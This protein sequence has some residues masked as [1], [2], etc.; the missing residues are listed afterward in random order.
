MQVESAGGEGMLS[1][2]KSVYLPKVFAFRGVDV[3][4]VVVVADVMDYT[5][6]AVLNT[7]YVRTIQRG[8]RARGK[9]LVLIPIGNAIAFD[10]DSQV[11]A[12]VVLPKFSSVRFFSPF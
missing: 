6:R 3:V 12:W 5:H 4:L 9:P 8:M 2:W 11:T 10:I 7:E 1:V